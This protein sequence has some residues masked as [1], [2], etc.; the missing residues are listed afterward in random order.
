MPGLIP[1]LCIMLML[2]QQYLSVMLKKFSEQ[3]LLSE[4][5]GNWGNSAA[6]IKKSL[7]ICLKLENHQVKILFRSSQLSSICVCLCDRRCTAVNGGNV[8]QLV[9]DYYGS[10]LHC[11]LHSRRSE[12][13]YMRRLTEHILPLVLPPRSTNCKFVLLSQ[14][15][16]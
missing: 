13:E 12:L 6:V 9:L 3:I 14:F 7:V 15:N 2:H 11:A 10:S 8:E 16:N 4:K 1:Q 5:F